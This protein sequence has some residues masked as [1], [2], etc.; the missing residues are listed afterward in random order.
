MHQYI[1][2][3]FW[4]R[5]GIYGL[6]LAGLLVGIWEWEDLAI[7]TRSVWG[8]RATLALGVPLAL[9]VVNRWGPMDVPY[10]VHVVALITMWYL[11]P[12]SIWN[13]VGSAAVLAATGIQAVSS[14]G[15]SLRT[16]V[17]LVMILVLTLVLSL[18]VRR[19]TAFRFRGLVYAVVMAI[20]VVN[21]I[22]NHNPTKDLIVTVTVASSV[23]TYI[24]GRARRQQQWAQDIYRAEHDALTGALTRHGLDAWL[25]RLTPH[26]RS[27]GLI[28]ACDLDNFK[29]FNDTW[30]HDLGDQVLREFARRLEASLR[31]QD[32]LV[33]PGGD[34]FTVW[35]PG[36]RAEQAGHI[37]ERL[38]DTVTNRPYDLSTGPFHLGVSMGW[39]CGVLSEDTAR[40]AD[41]NLLRAKRQGKNRVADPHHRSDESPA[42][43]AVPAALLGWLSDAARA[44]WSHWPSAAILTNTAGRI[45]AVNA[46]YERLSGRTWAEVADVSLGFHGDDA[47]PFEG[48]REPW[49]T[50]Q[51]GQPWHGTL[52]TRRPDGSTWLAS[53]WIIPIHVG[54]Q[55]IGY[56]RHVPEQSS[57]PAPSVDDIAPR[58]QSGRWR[59]LQTLTTDIV[60]QPLIDLRTESVFGHEALMRPRIQGQP[61]SPLDV[62]T[63]ATQYGVDDQVDELCLQTVRNTLGAMGE[64][65]GDQKLFVNVRNITLQ[66]PPTVRRV[67]QSLAEVVP[68]GQLVVEVSEQGTSAIKDWETLASLYPHVVFAQDDVGAGEADLAR[69]VQFRPAWVKIDIALIARI[70]DD[71]ISRELVGSLTQWAHGMAAHVI[72]EGVETVA[73][74]D[75]LR[76][77]G[78]DAGQG[79]LWAQPSPQLTR[80][81]P[82]F[83]QTLDLQ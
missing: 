64:W 9:V 19:P 7:R 38:H 21:M 78:V 73:Q 25:R 27:M 32:A 20:T 77:L 14:F 8:S 33:R 75:I 23:A 65:P 69:L 24:L 11:L 52:A 54:S 46:A 58:Q 80:T 26:A 71:P 48:D 53:Q 55:L 62:F 50:I 1:S 82:R 81:V 63:E 10:G 29:W 83:A 16:T 36:I 67:L 12:R 2:L 15:W 39:A 43:H 30:G 40:A 42:G 79:Y 72:A 6:L 22:M 17:D 44:L 51:A 47:I 41:Q 56:W 76:R 4:P 61:A 13:L 31:E 70:V 68:W 45:V 18:S 35:I 34:E 37:T 49:E 66:S 60:F 59:L 74:A 28:V 5:A 3:S 57:D